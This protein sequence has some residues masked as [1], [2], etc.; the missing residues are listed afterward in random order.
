MEGPISPDGMRVFASSSEPD[1]EKLPPSDDKCEIIYRS[2]WCR[3]YHCGHRDARVFRIRAF[4]V[5][6][7]KIRQKERCAECFLQHVREKVIRCALCGLPIFPG[8]PVAL[9]HR[10][11]EGLQFEVA[12]FTEKD[13]AIGCLRWDCCPCGGFFAG[14]WTENGFRH[15]SEGDS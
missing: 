6:T 10:K 1:R 13:A 3:T 7:K 14:H 9:Y 15:F 8:D 2:W 5:E 12:S 11:S 4:G